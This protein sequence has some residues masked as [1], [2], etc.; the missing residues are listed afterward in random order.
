MS[1]LEIAPAKNLRKLPV[2]I[3]RLYQKLSEKKGTIDDA[4]EL[5]ALVVLYQDFQVHLRDMLPRR[6]ADFSDTCRLIGDLLSRLEDGDTYLD[7]WKSAWEEP[8]DPANF[9]D[10]GGMPSLPFLS[11]LTVCQEQVSSHNYEEMVFG[12]IPKVR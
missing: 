10:D 6:A 2:E 4:R 7:A 9:D 3:T 12:R 11:T 8:V 5:G 1:T